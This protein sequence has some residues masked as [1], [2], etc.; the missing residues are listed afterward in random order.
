MAAADFLAC[1]V[2]NGVLRV[3]LPVAA[4]VGLLYPLD[5]RNHRLCP[6]HVDINFAG[7]ADQTENAVLLTADVRNSYVV[8]VEQAGETVHVFLLDIL[9]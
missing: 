9:L 3:E 7:V 1:N 4:L 5:I 6:E 2:H 8:T